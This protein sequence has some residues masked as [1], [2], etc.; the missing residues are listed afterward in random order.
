VTRGCN[1]EPSQTTEPAV[2][3]SGRFS[4]VGGDPGVDFVNTVDSWWSDAPVDRLTSYDDL[5]DWSAEA[6][7]VCFELLAS[8]RRAASEREEDAQRALRRARSFRGHLYRILAAAVSSRPAAVED[9]NA[10]TSLARKAAAH[11]RLDRCG[12][13][14]AWILDEAGRCELDWPVWEL[15][16]AAVALL[17]SESLQR[18]RRCADGTCGWL[19]IDQSRNHSRRWCDMAT[20]GNRA[21]ARRNYARRRAQRIAPPG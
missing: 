6:G 18:V 9:L 10:I 2:S 7:L 16:R 5:L 4:F 12:D 11:S 13:R 14:F 17:T 1:T 3:S 15:A 19:F 20:C 21:K 8:L